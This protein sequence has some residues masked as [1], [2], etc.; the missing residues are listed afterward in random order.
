MCIYNTT[1]HVCIYM[2][3]TRT[4]TTHL[5]NNNNNNISVVT[6]IYIYAV[7]AV[8]F[9]LSAAWPAER[10]VVLATNA[11][12]RKQKSQDTTMPGGTFQREM[13]YLRRDVCWRVCS[14]LEISPSSKTHL[15]TIVISSMSA[16]APRR[17]GAVYRTYTRIRRLIRRLNLKFY[18]H[19]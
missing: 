10:R 18:P 3:I 16:P 15:C 8:I 4:Y 9:S 11:V 13:T 19:R 7:F 17:C 6:C 12:P 5:Y 2:Q 14:W 1:R